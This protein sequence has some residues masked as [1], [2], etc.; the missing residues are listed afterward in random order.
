MEPKK[1]L[2]TLALVSVVLIAGC[3]KDTFVE[4][5]GICPI[6]ISTV[7]ANLATGVP[8]NQVITATFNKVMNPATITQA[9]FTVKG[10]SAITGTVSYSGT[11][12]TFVPSSPLAPNT[13]YTG[14][15]T[16][17]VKDLI[18]QS[19]KYDYVWTFTTI[20]QYTVT[21]S[22]NPI[23]GGTTSGSGTFNSGSSVTVTAAANTGYTFTNWT[24]SGTV[25]STTTPYIFTI[26]GNRTLVA[27]YT[28]RYTVALSTNP[29]T[30]SNQPTGSGT[31]NSGASVTV[32]AVANTGY[33]FTNWTESGTAVSTTAAYTFTIS[34]NRTLVA[35]YTAAVSSYTV[36]V[37]SNPLAGGT[38]TGAGTYNSGASV[39]VTAVANTG[40]TFT[41]WTESGTA[42]STTAAYTF[43]ISGNRT[44][45]ANYTAAVSSYT[46][47][48][49]ASPLAGGTQTGAGAYNSGAS[50]T[51]TATP[52]I[53]YTFTYWTEFGTVASTNP[54]YA[55]TISGNRTLVANY[56]S[57][58]YSVTLSANPS[59]GGTPSGGGAFNYGNSATVTANTATGYTFTNWTESGTIVSTTAS[60]TFT[61]SA[62]RTLV[63]N[64]TINT[65][66]LTV[67]A[68]NGSVVKDPNQATY[69]YGTSVTLTATPNTGYSFSGWTGDT[70][71]D[72]P[73]NTL[74][75]IMN[76][77]KTVTAN[78]IA[79]YTVMVSPLP[80]N[81][82]SASGGGTFN[83][84]S[85]VTVSGVANT[86]YTF[87]KWTE[88]VNDVSL[89]ANYTFT[90]S[91]D[92]TLVANYTINTY[93]LNV[94]ATNG[95]VS[96]DP[97]TGPY[98]YGTTVTI[99]ASANSG[100]TFTSWSGDYVGTVSPASI[101]MNANKNITANF[102][103]N[104]AVCPTIVDLGK[105]GDYVILAESG[106]STTGTTSVTGNMGISPA[107]ATF[108]TGFD[109][110]LPAG[111]A[112]STSSLVV[113]NIYA[114]GYASPTPSN[115]TTAV[116]NMHTA[117]TTANGLVSPAPTTEYMAG[118]LNGQT[119]AAGIWKWS[120]GV[121]IT[122]GITLDGG[123]DAC[124]TWIF[125]IAGDLTVANGA[126]ITLSHGAD[127]KNIFWV[128]AGSKAQ[129]GTTVDFKGNILCKTL[130]SLN[131]GANVKGRLL[132]Q[133]AVTLIA[134]TVVLP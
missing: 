89:L 81:G 98:N 29:S 90:I 129:L 95:T 131:T 11:T 68:V 37:S 33:T 42:V 83:S 18:R 2:T 48:L 55:F 117:Y 4:I 107:A 69:N 122:N 94:T 101:L 1:L 56:A 19:P 64:F 43:T 66:T 38:Q 115:L 104:S 22:S 102:T 32:T 79:I 31:F 112:F 52:A 110:I 49:S 133:T 126:I 128:V 47:T 8:L 9:S 26:S 40:Y 61:I 59:A 41:N 17:S 23:A 92:R 116:D 20:S 39:T 6:V 125:Q 73:S 123:S 74:T 119:L 36:A 82:G 70:K 3:K 108:I 99:T 15:I 34:G 80:A 60:Y 45:V 84:G 28:A 12:A 114:P 93:T 100:Y 21:V 75:V 16:R 118:N 97:A 127:A 46:V 35:N 5:P 130:I 103:L 106:I 63:A 105:S 14:T 57:I 62:N 67:I 24:E 121:S 77:N 50:V 58:V 120:S 27:N 78:F 53:G 134:S 30:L 7:P 109:L 113:G 86:G 65:Y 85:S 111:G 44:L 72:Y 10:A 25:V 76:A 51:V 71:G 88:G 91:G 96:K 132:A 13:T 54:T 87:T 124:A